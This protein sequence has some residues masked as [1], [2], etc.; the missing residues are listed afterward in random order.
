MYDVPHADDVRIDYVSLK[1]VVGKREV[2]GKTQ[3]N[4]KAEVAG[5]MEVVG[6]TEVAGKTQT[7]GKTEVTGKTQVTGKIE[8]FTDL[9]V[10]SV[11]VRAINEYLHWQW[12]KAV[13]AAR[14]AD[15]STALAEISSAWVPK[16]AISNHFSIRF[17]APEIIAPCPH[18]VIL[19][20]HIEDIR[21]Y[22]D[23][24]AVTYVLVFLGG[25]V[26][27]TGLLQG[28]KADISKLDHR[29]CR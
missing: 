5:K 17:G 6:K 2:A 10:H 16:C 1:D 21:W 9:T 3:M 26:A 14:T 11:D 23:L 4:G 19:L 7:A 25:W 20:F 22:E 28:E 15:L 24:N 27:L 13:R 8:S 29:I 18:E 12:Q